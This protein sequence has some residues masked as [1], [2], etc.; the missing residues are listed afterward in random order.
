MI[1]EVTAGTE[2]ASEG[3]ADGEG[4]DTAEGSGEPSECNS[5]RSGANPLAIIA[6]VVALAGVGGAGYY[7]MK[8]KR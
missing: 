5:E 1:G 6:G 4:N 7:I 8:K 3:L 2:T